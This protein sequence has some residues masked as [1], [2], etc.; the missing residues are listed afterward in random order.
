LRDLTARHGTLLIFDEVITGFRVARGGAQER[1]GVQPDLTVL[2]K[3]IG[4]GLPVGAYGGLSQIMSMVA[5]DGPVY[6]AGTL[7]GNPLAM[8][9][10][11]ATLAELTPSVYQRLEEAGASLEAG[12]ARTAAGVRVQ[13]RIA[14]VGSLL[15]VFFDDDPGGTRFARFFHAMLAA[16][17]HLPPSPHEAWFIS[18]A[19]GPDELDQTIDAAAAAFEAARPG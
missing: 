1:Y 7:S 5:P 12:L 16:G 3:I 4:G 6:Q 9:A 8:A 10:G 19:H 11:L 14:R 15:T 13:I 17:I 18:A 2:G